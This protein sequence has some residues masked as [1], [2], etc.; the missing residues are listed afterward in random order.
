MLGREGAVYHALASAQEFAARR[1]R[2][3]RLTSSYA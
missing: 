3:G 1:K 2:D